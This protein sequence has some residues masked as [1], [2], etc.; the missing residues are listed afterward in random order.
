MI[1]SYV[2][3]GG[4]PRLAGRAGRELDGVSLRAERVFH[5]KSGLYV[6][7]H[8]VV[9]WASG[10]SIAGRAAVYEIDATGV[11]MV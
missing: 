2:V 9:M 4:K 11:R 8:G 1:E 5:P 10:H 7:I 3:E 6:L